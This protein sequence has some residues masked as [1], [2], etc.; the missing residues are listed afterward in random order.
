MVDAEIEHGWAPLFVLPKAWGEAAF[1]VF[2]LC[3]GFGEKFL[4]HHSGLRKTIHAFLDL[5]VDPTIFVGD[6]GEVVF[7]DYV[8][9]NAVEMDVH[10]FKFFHWS[11]EVKTLYVKTHSSTFRIGDNCIRPDFDLSHVGGGGAD[12]LFIFDFVAT[13]C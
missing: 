13:H 7:I 12:V 10:V 1:I 2:K 9:W 8:F 4:C 3:E 5:D 6:M 11:V